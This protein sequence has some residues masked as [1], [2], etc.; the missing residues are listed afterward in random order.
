[1]RTATG[2]G[3]SVVVGEGEP[4]RVTVVVTV[5][6]IVLVIPAVGSNDG[7]ATASV[8]RGVGEAGGGRGVA[9]GGAA[10][11]GR[12]SAVLV[13]VSISATLE[14]VISGVATSVVTS[15]GGRQATKSNNPIN[16]YTNNQYTSLTVR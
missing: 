10:V 14:T 8:G 15:P 2:L 4:L 1:M 7:V 6:V 13:A 9:E 3:V 11:V 5:V 12:G 16:P